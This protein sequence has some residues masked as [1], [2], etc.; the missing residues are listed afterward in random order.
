MF[1]QRPSTSTYR[2]RTSPH[3]QMYGKPHRESTFRNA[4]AQIRSAGSAPTRHDETSWRDPA[5]R[6]DPGSAFHSPL[7]NSKATTTLGY[8]SLAGE[9]RGSRTHPGCFPQRRTLSLDLEARRVPSVPPL[10]PQARSEDEQSMDSE[11]EDDQDA[12]NGASDPSSSSESQDHHETE[13]D[14]RVIRLVGL[15]YAVTETDIVEFFSDIP[16]KQVVVV[17]RR[18]EMH[19]SGVAYAELVSANDIAAALQMHHRFLKGR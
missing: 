3:R 2:H 7:Q 15:A 19:H 16:V 9:R 8:S 11:S 12:S 17:Q 14:Q 5:F 10:F 13:L 1:T 4:D 18:S 6:A